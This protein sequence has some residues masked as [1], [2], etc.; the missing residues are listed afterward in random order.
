MILILTR[1][2]TQEVVDSFLKKADSKMAV[3]LLCQAFLPYDAFISETAA[4][5]VISS[6]DVFGNDVALVRGGSGGIMV[7]DSSSQ[8]EQSEVPDFI[9]RNFQ[10]ECNCLM[11]IVKDS[12]VGLMFLEILFQELSALLCSNQTKRNDQSLLTFEDKPAEGSTKHHALV[13]VNYIAALCENLNEQV[14]SH[15]D[16]LLGFLLA[17]FSQ[18]AHELVNEEAGIACETLT[19]AIGL[20]SALLGTKQNLKQYH[21][22]LMSLQPHLEALSKR[23]P[24]S[25]TR[26]ILCELHICIVTHGA[27]WFETPQQDKQKQLVNGDEAESLFRNAMKELLDPLLPVRAHALRQLTS[28]V[29]TKDLEAISNSEKLLLIF[30]QQLEHSDSYVYLA[31]INGLVALGDKFPDQVVDTLCR[32]FALF[33]GSPANNTEFKSMGLI[34]PVVSGQVKPELTVAIRLKLGEAIVKLSEALGDMIPHYRG[35]LLSALLSS[36]KDSDELVRASSLSNL[37]AVCKQLRFG[38]GTVVHEV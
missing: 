12:P 32:E 6:I 20:I 33:Y 9:G 37:A 5:H 29:Q 35:P 21:S 19:L 28:L 2:L 23:H 1:T 38:L 10:N 18:S 26:D 16:C 25:D 14:V 36:V 3:T 4:G 7:I 27:V 15:P 31:A 30:R 22:Q 8:C 24:D 11:D 17:S 13:L 34:K